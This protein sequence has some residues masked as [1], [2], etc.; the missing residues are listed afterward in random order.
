MVDSAGT[1]SNITAITPTATGN[2]FKQFRY[3]WLG[4][5]QGK[6]SLYLVGQGFE[7]QS[8]NL[9]TLATVETTS[10]ADGYYGLSAFL[11]SNLQSIGFNDI[12]NSTYGA[13][14]SISIGGPQ[15]TL[16]GR[17]PFVDIY[18]TKFGN[19]LTG[20][21]LVN[22]VKFLYWDGYVI[23]VSTTVGQPQH[24]L[25]ISYSIA[26]FDDFAVNFLKEVGVYKDN[27]GAWS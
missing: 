27:T 4:V 15:G 14:G 5:P 1:V 24:A 16:Q 22:D 23:P 11:T 19:N 25:N 6:T 9:T 8:F 13:Y 2:T 20:T 7:A 21:G 26:D 12:L 10:P 3:S 17:I 18:N